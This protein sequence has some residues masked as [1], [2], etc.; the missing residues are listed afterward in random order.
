MQRTD[1]FGVVADSIK[2]LTATFDLTGSDFK[3]N[4]LAIFT[5]LYDKGDSYEVVLDENNTCL[6]PHE[7][8]KSRGFS[9][10]LT[11]FYDGITIPTNKVNVAVIESGYK[12]GKTPADPTP[13]VYE[14]IVEMVEEKQDKL[15]AGDNITIEDNVISSTGGSEIDHIQVNG[16]E[17]PIVDKTVDIPVPTK[18]SELNNDSG[19]ITDDSI[20]IKSVTLAGEELV[21]DMDKN[22]N[23]PVD[24]EVLGESDNPVA[25]SAVAN[26]VNNLASVFGQ[27]TQRIEAIAKGRATGYVFDTKAD[28]DLAL[29]DTEFVSK[30]VLGD[31]LYIRATDTPDYWWDGENAQQLETQKVDLSEYVKNTDYATYAKAGVVTVSLGTYGLNMD[32]GNIRVQPATTV[33][34][35]QSSNTS[36]PINPLRQHESTFYG[37]A[38]ASGDTTQSES[39]NPV[40]QYTDDAKEKIKEMFG[41]SDELKLKQDILTA[42][43]NI[44]IDE[45]NVISATNNYDNLSNRPITRLDA[46]E[47]DIN[48]LV[49][50]LYKTKLPA[51]L[52]YFDLGLNVATNALMSVKTLSGSVNQAIIYT[53][54]DIIRFS[55]DTK[56]Q[57]AVRQYVF[58]EI[59][60]KQDK[61]LN[62]YNDLPQDSLPQINGNALVG[63]KTGKELGLASTSDIIKDYNS[64]TN[65]PIVNL[66]VG[67]ITNPLDIFSLS[68]GLYKVSKQGYIGIFNSDGTLR[69]RMLVYVGTE[70]AI[71]R[72]TATQAQAATIQTHNAYYVV[73]PD[74]QTFDEHKLE[75]VSNKV[76]AITDENKDSTDSYTSVKAVTDYVKSAIYNVLGGAS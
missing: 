52:K 75:D 55:Y 46:T 30:L 17:Q 73:T 57:V 16:T 10:C 40:G 68:T 74:S 26:T 49:T 28:M 69:N 6:V 24:S 38:K 41:I 36:R 76:D 56:N 13:S 1:D 39:S 19:Y 72:P 33:D 45:N 8:I 22:I 21:P 61:L 54:N 67:T 14:Q 48:S 7:I 44:T 25:S 35:K 34:I 71:F 50:G 2:Y 60:G 64:L 66:E 15:I 62:G 70:I 5:P 12:E 32:K 37:L 63:N 29:E 65:I 43:E 53:E 3:G 4:L 20:P 27:E 42:G 9:V 18:T 58:L 51:R 47:I 59:D 11:S 31:N 23:I